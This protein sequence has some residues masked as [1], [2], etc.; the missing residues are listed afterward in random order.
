MRLTDKIRDQEKD[1]ETTLDEVQQQK[2]DHKKSKRKDSG[3][4]VEG[5]DNLLVRLAKCCNPVPGDEIIGYITKGRGVSVHRKNCPNMQTEEYKDRL[6]DVRWET[7]NANR[8]QYHVD[9]EIS[10]YDRRGLLNDV[11]QIINEYG[12]NIIGVNSKTDKNKLAVIHL[13]ILINN[14]AHLRKTVDQIKQIKDIYTVK[15]VVQ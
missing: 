7:T 3:V 4:I 12:T 14:T 10:G 13:T 15:R 5:V 8:K 2:P 1:L 6:L 9:L 11:L